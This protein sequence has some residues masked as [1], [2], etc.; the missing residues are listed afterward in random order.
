MSALRFAPLPLLFLLIAACGGSPADDQHGVTTDPNAAIGFVTENGPVPETASDSRGDG[1]LRDADGRPYGYGLLGET[2]PDIEAPTLA[3]GTFR[4]ADINQWTVLKVWGIWCGDCRRDSPYVAQLATAIAD[5][6][7][8][9]FQSIHTPPNAR[10]ADEAYGDYGSVEAYFDAEGY[11]FPVAVDDDAAIR[12]AL[13]I[14]W[15]PTYLLVGPDG[16]VRGFRTD[17]SVIGENAVEQFL[18][19]I[20]A[21]RASVERAALLTPRIGPDGAMQLEG[22]T[23]FTRAS[24][25]AAFPSL[26]IH[27]GTEMAEG[28]E[29]PVFHVARRGDVLSTTPLFTVEPSWDRG[30]VFAV[31]TRSR[32]VIG[33]GSARIGTTRL[34]D[35]SAAQQAAC[36]VGTEAYSELL[37]CAQAGGTGQFAHVFG[38]PE[39][40]E[41]F[42]PYASEAIQTTGILVE[43]RYLPPVPTY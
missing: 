42:F 29:Y 11:S 38:P 25:A 7:D 37:I 17:L 41:G 40:F 2:L 14:A 23:P 13:M 15:T 1:V 18:A 39:G 31:A 4:T 6:P 30:H 21:T 36:E 19:D 32:D 8:L 9:D 26:D 28:E 10:R 16:V 3:G 27:G 24:L 22:T 33:P 34:G 5:Q 35:L 12:D 43:M 20:A